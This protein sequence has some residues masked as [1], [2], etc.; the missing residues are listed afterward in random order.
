[1]YHDG[2]VAEKVPEKVSWKLDILDYPRI[3]R[4]I[5]RY[6]RISWSIL[7]YPGISWDSNKRRVKRQVMCVVKEKVP[8]KLDILGYPRIY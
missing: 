1:L 6:T 2:K 4:D 3:S 5:P 8:G 7:V